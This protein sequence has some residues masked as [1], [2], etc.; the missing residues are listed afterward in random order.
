MKKVVA[1]STMVNTIKNMKTIT[2]KKITAM[3]DK[4]NKPTIKV[5]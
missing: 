5:D 4:Y 1:I 2:I 3:C